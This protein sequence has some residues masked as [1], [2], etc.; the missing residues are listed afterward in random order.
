MASPTLAAFL[1]DKSEYVVT[2]A[3]RAISD[4]TLVTDALPALAAYLDKPTFTNE[5]LLRRVINANVYAKSETNTTA[6]NAERLIRFARRS[7]PCLGKL[8]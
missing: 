7:D 1:N 2:N 6:D 4:D 3:A 8:G 5:Q